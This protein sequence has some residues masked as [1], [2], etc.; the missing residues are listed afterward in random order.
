MANIAKLHKQIAPFKPFIED[1]MNWFPYMKPV[2]DIRPED[3]PSRA[4][5]AEAAY[6]SFLQE[7]DEA[8]V[9][10]VFEKVSQ[11]VGV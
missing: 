3:I 8:Y 10:S 5:K 7:E 2:K 4:D 9:K 11:S 6:E 1:E